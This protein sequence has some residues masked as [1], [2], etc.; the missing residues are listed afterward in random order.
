MVSFY[1]ERTVK[2][3]D[4]AVSLI[5]QSRLPNRLTYIRCTTHTE[6]ADAIREMKIRGAPAIGVA[7]AMGLALTAY[8]S[9]AKTTRELLYELEVAGGE[10]IET[11]PTAINLK[12]G[13]NRICRRAS[14]AARGDVKS[15]KKLVVDEAVRMG[16][17]DVEVN[18]R[19]GRN[20]STLLEDGDRVL[21]H[22]K[23]L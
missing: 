7:A 20:G 4:G 8:N 1:T 22:C 13:V 9:K 10:L 5:D 21:T 3:V 12:W 11:R 23:W 15:L 2:W 6:V 19:I 14:E 17:E 18:R 16:D